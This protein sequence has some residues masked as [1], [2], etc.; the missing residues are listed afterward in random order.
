[1]K[2]IVFI[3]PK[4]PGFH[5]FSRV[6][7]PR[8]GNILLG[9]LLKKKGYEVRVYVEELKSLDFKEILKADLV[10][11]ST[12]T[13]TAPR[14]HNIAKRVKKAGI[15]V[16]MGGTH[17]T[18]LPDE[19]LNYADYVVR[20]EG[21]ETLVE[22][23]DYL[24]KGGDLRKI[25]GLSFKENGINIH[26]PNRSFLENQELNPIPDYSLIEGWK[27]PKEFG[28][29]SRFQWKSK[30]V[31]SIETSRGCPYSCKFCTVNVFFG[32]NYR[33][34]SVD[35]VMEELRYQKGSHI[36]FCD[37]NFAFNKERTKE[38]LRRM[39]KEKIPPEWSAQVRAD[40]AKDDELLFLMKKSNC[41]CVFVGFESINPKTLELYDK[42]QTLE[43]I[44][45][46]IKR[47]HDFGINIHGMFVL[48]SDEDDIETIRETAK[49][50]KKNNIDSVQLA[51]LTPGPGSE[52]YKE[53][54]ENNRLLTEDWSLYD[55]L[56]VVSEPKNMTPYE[57]QKEVL[58]ASKN[59]YSW[60]EIFKRLFRGD[61]FYFLIKLYGKYIISKWDA[62]SKDYIFQLKED[63]Y[64]EVK[65]VFKREKRR[66]LRRVGILYDSMMKNEYRLSLEKFF[67]ELNV[68]VIN[69]METLPKSYSLK[70][71]TIPFE[72]L[73]STLSRL[74]NKV[75][76]IILTSTRDA[77]KSHLTLHSYFGE[78]FIKMIRENIIQCPQIIPLPI[79]FNAEP[80]YLHYTK[81]GLIFT[82]NLED[83]R[84]AYLKAF[85]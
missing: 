7:I 23:V 25:K 56:Y 49:F 26:N 51:I 81:I 52:I 38:L 39:I 80:V 1:M 58:K 46:S 61:I 63:L 30:G 2:K 66:T 50:A 55:S 74:R 37:D 70:E 42:R 9:T 41:F 6:V 48:G 8:V 69:V 5:Y 59:F 53:Y 44:E 83:I 82:D 62:I 31:V 64:S 36:F 14:A 65:K 13:T 85:I 18:F 11:I 68:K 73:S 77:K 16:V 29:T 40:A 67:K 72:F 79:D 76:C 60:L 47:F 3:E 75:D 22:L 45:Y 4:A 28:K 17:V 35:R 32:K 33:Y 57:L 78:A 34:K 12:I 54:K 71:K 10:G 27:A 21:E 15:P 20:G 43:E 19:A 84:R 24:E